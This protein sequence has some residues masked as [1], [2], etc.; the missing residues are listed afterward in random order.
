MRNDYQSDFWF[1]WS[2]PDSGWILVDCQLDMFSQESSVILQLTE[3]GGRIST[4]VLPVTSKGRVREYVFLP[5][6]LV[7][8]SFHW[9]SEL[10]NAPD[11]IN[12]RIH[13]ISTLLCWVF[14][15]G[16]VIGVALRQPKARLIK[17]GFRWYLPFVDFQKAYRIMNGF[18]R[19]RLGIPYDRWIQRYDV[20]KEEDKKKICKM[21]GRFKYTPRIT[22]VLLG[23]VMRK[24]DC[25]ISGQLYDHYDVIDLMQLLALDTSERRNRWFVFMEGDITLREHALFWIAFVINSHPEVE[26]IYSD[27][28]HIDGKGTRSNHC[29]KPDW[30]PETFYSSGYFGG[31]LVCKWQKVFEEFLSKQSLSS[32]SNYDLVLKYL[33]QTSAFELNANERVVHIPAVLFHLKQRNRPAQNNINSLRAHYETKGITANIS[34]MGDSLLQVEYQPRYDPLI[35][36]IVPTKDGMDVLKACIESVLLKSSYKNVEVIIVDNQSCKPETLT[37]FKYLTE[38]YD[39]VRV[40]QYDQPFNYSAINNFAA[41]HAAG[42]VLCLLNNDTEVIT[43]RWLDIMLGQLQQPNVG[44]VGAKLLFANDTVQHI[45]DAVGPGGCADHF[46]SGLAKGKRGYCNRAVIAQDVSAVTAACLL[47][48]KSVFKDVGGFNA[49]DLAVTF[50]DVDFC[51]RVREAGF[52][53]VMTPHAQLYHYE[54]VSRGKDQSPEKAARAKREVDYMKK[55]WKKTLLHDPFYNPNLTYGRPNFRL[56]HAPMVDRPWDTESWWKL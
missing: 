16:R 54:S 27:H 35:S 39:N 45:G 18:R 49:T 40:I 56:S 31:L 42:E 20:L 14:Q 1:K 30:S 17:A 36:I 11:Q 5:T 19:H 37:Y 7:D 22:V 8:I 48:Y 15:W 47:V 21:S 33:E 23:E 29:F 10:I 41:D 43:H 3:V 50:N 46:L 52:R 13:H 26:V 25:G 34:D 4:L 53:V 51:L 28:D 6:S 55:R 38:E 12:V 44:A 24:A 2:N 32:I 9:P